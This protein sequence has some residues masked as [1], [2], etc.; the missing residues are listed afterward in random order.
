MQKRRSSRTPAALIESLEDRLL[1]AVFTVTNTSDSGPGS[2]RA[3]L[4]QSDASPGIDTIAFN[5]TSADKTIHASAGFDCWNAVIIDGTTQPGYAGKPLVRVDGAGTAAGTDGFRLGGGCTLKGLSITGFGGEG[6]GLATGTGAGGNAVQANWIGVTPSGAAAPNAGQGIGVYTPGNLIG[7]PNKGDGNLISANAGYAVWIMGGIFGNDAPS[8]IVQNNLIGT[9]ADGLSSLG[10]YNGIG[11]QN[12]PNNQ[13]LANVIAGA[14]EIQPNSGGDGIL[15]SGAK[16][17]GTIIKANYI[18]TDIT[19]TKALPNQQYGIEIQTANNVIGGASPADR[20]IISGN[21]KAGVIFYQSNAAGN[22]VQGNYI[23]TDVT[24]TK[25]LGNAQQGVAF[26]ESAGSNTIGGTAAGAG[27]TIASNG[28]VGIA[29]FPGNGEIIQ[30]NRIGIGVGGQALGN[31]SYGIVAYNSTGTAIGGPT[32]AAGNVIAYNAL[33]G[34]GPV[35][36]GADK[37]NNTLFGNLGDPVSNPPPPPAAPVLQSAASCKAHGATNF[38]IALPLTGTAGVECRLVSGGMTIVFTFDKSIASASAAVTG[39]SATVLGAVTPGA[40][41]TLS[42]N[43]TNIANAQTITL[44]LTN[45]I[46]SDG[47]TLASAS[48]SCR[49]LQGDVNGNGTVSAADVAMIKANVGQSVSA[50]NFRTDINENG[51]ISAADVNLAK[52][53]AGTV[54]AAVVAAAAPSAT[55]VTASEAAATAPAQTVLKTHRRRH[56]HA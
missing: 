36:A 45:I 23:G 40:G 18:G 41:N 52:A 32:A 48:V 37:G 35:D 39:G 12:S 9:T 34:I 8:N 49:V 44:S 7:G 30:G 42:V 13:L 14:Q 38:D 2:L 15:L 6:I 28:D 31:K 43:L 27:N 3:A 22:L 47:G 21:L 17:T 51:L 1:L 5:I 19:G 16:T 50:S 46:A 26:A 53:N 10:T 11:I 29:M 24:G 25:A 54:A 33:Q 20:N 56:R 55:E 4:Q